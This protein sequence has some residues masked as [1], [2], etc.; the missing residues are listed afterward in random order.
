MMTWINRK[1]KSK[2][3]NIKLVPR[4][5]DW[6]EERCYERKG[7]SGGKW[8]SVRLDDITGGRGKDQ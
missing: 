3:R 5:G 1:M 2:K 4:F 8:M 7:K 6:I